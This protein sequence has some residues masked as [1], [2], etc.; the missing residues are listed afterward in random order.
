MFNS[1]PITTWE[2]AAAIFNWAGGF[3]PVF[4]FW[5]MVAL[6]II[7]VLVSLCAENAAE[8]THGGG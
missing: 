2:G 3:G 6:C 7:P 1:S 5:A 4:W 8:K